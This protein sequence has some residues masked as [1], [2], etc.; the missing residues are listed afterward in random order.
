M[1]EQTVRKLT[2]CDLEEL[3]RAAADLIVELA[4]TA[5]RERGFF[6]LSLAGGHTPARL[7]ELLATDYRERINWRQT[8][9]FWGDERL[10]PLDHKDSNYRLAAEH[11]LPCLPPANI[12]TV[13]VTSADPETAARLYEE[14][15]ERFRQEQGI[16]SGPIFDCVLLGMGPDGHCASLFPGSPLLEEDKRLVAAIAEPA[17]SPPVVR[18]TLTLPALAASR[19]VIFMVSGGKKLEIVSEILKGGGIQFPA[20]RVRSQG[21]VYW[22]L[23]P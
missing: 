1:S 9:V 20:A 6:S 11:L 4:E 8:F 15:I 19:A 5:V 14:E 17:G 10:V 23:A 12:K 21:A 22:L 13:A 3:S 18:I 7:Y 16:A 2:Y